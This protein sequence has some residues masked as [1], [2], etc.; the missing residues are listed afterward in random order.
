MKF[1]VVFQYIIPLVTFYLV[2]TG[3]NLIPIHLLINISISTIISTW[4]FNIFVYVCELIQRKNS[5]RKK[6]N[7]DKDEEDIL[8]FLDNI[9][10][11]D[12]NK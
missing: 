12:K 1:F 5:I 6:N 10:H 2:F 3:L 9:D 7:I 11:V 4:I 8:S